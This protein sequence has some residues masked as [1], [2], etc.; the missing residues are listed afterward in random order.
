MTANEHINRE[1]K[2]A[3][4]AIMQ[5][6]RIQTPR[7]FEEIIRGHMEMLAVEL[8]FMPYRNNKPKRRKK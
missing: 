2:A 3:A 6:V 7:S 5:A 8:A 4:E 1:S